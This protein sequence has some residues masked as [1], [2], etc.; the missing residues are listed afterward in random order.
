M[1]VSNRPEPNQTVPQPYRSS[2]KTVPQQYRTKLCV[3]VLLIPAVH[4]FHLINFLV[5]FKV[6]ITGCLVVQS[7][8]DLFFCL[9][10]LT[11]W[12]T[13]LSVACWL[14]CSLEVVLLTG[15]CMLVQGSLH[16]HITSIWYITT[17]TVR[18][19]LKPVSPISK[20]ACRL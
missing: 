2:T 13:G 6:L 8:Y 9:A 18:P 10:A 16:N 12:I 20:W 4:V 17:Y 14:A 3:N 19:T 5:L 7:H 15:V 11:H 1:A